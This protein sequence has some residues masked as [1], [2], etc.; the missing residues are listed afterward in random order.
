M[1]WP[2]VATLTTATAATTA[3]TTTA[4]AAAI[5]A[6]TTTTA[7]PFFARPGNINS[8][9]PPV[10]ARA[11]HGIHGLLG[12]FLGAHGDESESA[13]AAAFAIS[14]EI[15]FEDG[16][17][18]GERVLKIVFGGVEGEISDKQFIIHAVILICFLESPAASESV[19]VSGLES[20]LNVAH[21]TIYHRLKVM[22]YPTIWHHRPFR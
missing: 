4:A 22:S 3:T 6:T 15:G 9:V 12:F 5:P 10:Q 13:R 8:E 11:V 19:P 14:H 7:G 2:A 17:V 1:P 16:A 18:R 20:S 21:V